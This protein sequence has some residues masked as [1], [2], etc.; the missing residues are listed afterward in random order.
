MKINWG[1]AIVLFLAVFFCLMA[2]FVTFALRQNNDLVTDDYYEKGANYS[3]TIERIKRS[4]HFKDSIQITQ[5]ATEIQIA[6]TQNI[7]IKADSFTVSYYCGSNRKNDFSI[8]HPAF[9]DSKTKQL[10]NEMPS[11][12]VQSK[13]QLHNSYYSVHIAWWVHSLQYEVDKELLI[14]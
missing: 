5:N 4:A 3:Q 11:I 14:Q 13:Q 8:Q 2:V 9:N 1:T 6:F 10:S 7:A 12:L